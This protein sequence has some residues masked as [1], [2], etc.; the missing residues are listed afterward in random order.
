MAEFKPLIKLRHQICVQK[1]IKIIKIFDTY[2][3]EKDKDVILGQWQGKK[4]IL[5]IGEHRPV[6]F[7]P[8]GYQGDYLVIPKIYTINKKLNYEIEQ[9]L[10]GKLLFDLLQKIKTNHLLAPGWLKP[11]IKSFWEWQY[12]GSGLKLK[13]INCRKKLE[14][15]FNQ[16]SH[17]IKHP[18]IAASIINNNKYNF[19]W[20]EHYPAK[21]KFA[22]DNLVALPERKIGFID[23]KGVSQRYW[24]YDL[25]WIVWPAWFNFN[26]TEIRLHHQH[27]KYL[28]NFFNLVYSLAPSSEKKNKR[29][30]ITKCWLVIFERI[31]GSYRDVAL[32][33]AHIKN[34]LNTKTKKN[35]FVNF[36]DQLLILVSS[37]L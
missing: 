28:K 16:G 21:W 17:L 1:G 10:D 4:I 22:T 14:Q 25:G 26:S 34:N 36:L 2:Q 7:F 9:Y 19:F 27:F 6:D 18:Q 15:F 37:E 32:D 30:F 20:A 33:I 5:R 3:K 24:G 11:V 29:I 12:I 13:K 23:L 8:D 31:I 35:L